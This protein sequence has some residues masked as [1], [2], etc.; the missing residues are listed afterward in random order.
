MRLIRQQMVE[1]A[2]RPQPTPRETQFSRIRWAGVAAAAAVA[3][4]CLSILNSD[5]RGHSLPK[6]IVP[7]RDLV[8]EE[9]P[10][11][12]V[13]PD[14]SSEQPPVFAMASVDQS[15]QKLERLESLVHDDLRDDWH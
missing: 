6:S 9:N 10:T 13:T 11:P 15:S 2:A 1:I 7:E 12:S 3:V 5:F 4:F 8:I 14:N